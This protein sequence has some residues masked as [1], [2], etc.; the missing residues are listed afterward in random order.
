MARDI[1][2]FLRK[3]AERRAAQQQ[4]RP[5]PQTPSPPADTPTPRLVPENRPMESRKPV[6]GV[7]SLELVEDEVEVIRPVGQT[8][9]E[10]VKSHIDTRD[11][12]QH[13][14]QLGARVGRAGNKMDR[15]VHE[16][17]E[18][19]LGQ[20]T[21]SPKKGSSKKTAGQR[22]PAVLIDAGSILG[23]LRSPRTVGQAILLA[24]LL[25]RPEFDEEV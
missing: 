17:F 12:S 6:G 20:L 5:V 8:V 13:A 2:E 3:A 23:M 1:E 7:E 4:G 14:E 25:K 22:Q 9:S 21:E 19:D 18:H 24:E 15:R 16:K 11:I 10:H